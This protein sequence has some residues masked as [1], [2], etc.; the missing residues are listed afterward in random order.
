V[1]SDTTAEGIGKLKPAFKE[2]GSVTAANASSI[3]DGAAAV[4]VMSAERA[5]KLG[6]A[7][8]AR[9]SAYATAA[10]RPSG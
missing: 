6:L 7:P 3:N 1:R 10:A 9:I 4:V 2:G 8:L 5:K